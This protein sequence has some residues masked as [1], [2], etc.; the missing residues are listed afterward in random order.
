MK[1]AAIVIG[2]YVV[3]LSQ[4]IYGCEVDRNGECHKGY[5]SNVAGQIIH[6]L[7]DTTSHLQ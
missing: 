3:V 4:G 2:L 1:I 6:V 7:N 5:F